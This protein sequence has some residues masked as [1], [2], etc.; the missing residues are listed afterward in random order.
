[1]KTIMLNDS[2][3]LE[4]IYQRTS[5]MQTMLEHLYSR[6][7]TP[8][9]CEKLHPGEVLATLIK[10]KSMTVKEFAGSISCNLQ[11]LQAVT[12]KKRGMPEYLAINLV[13][14]FELNLHFWMR[15]QSEYNIHQKYD[16]RIQKTTKREIIIEN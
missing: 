11:I 8:E 3:K 10:E 2:Q 7:F 6:S 13:K 16:E 5:Q 14:P 4:I 15:L 1:M 12:D 9:S